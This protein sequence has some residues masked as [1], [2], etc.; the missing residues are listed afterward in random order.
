MCRHYVHNATDPCAEERAEPP[1][2][3]EGA[4]F[5]D[6]FRPSEGRYE[7]RRGERQARAQANLDALFGG[8]ADA[9]AEDPQ[10]DEARAKLDELF[11]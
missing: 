10:A 1:V 11:R 7:A 2:Y 8:E 9:P 6:Y 3:K 4:N 5:C